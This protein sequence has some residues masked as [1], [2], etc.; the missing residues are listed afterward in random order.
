[1]DGGMLERLQCRRAAY[2]IGDTSPTVCTV[3]HQSEQRQE[4]WSCIRLSDLGQEHNCTGEEEARLASR[5]VGICTFLASSRSDENIFC[6]NSRERKGL[7]DTCSTTMKRS[8]PP[9]VASIG[10][11][12]C[13]GVIYLVL[14]RLPGYMGPP[15]GSPFTLFI[16]YEQYY[17]E[18]KYYWSIFS[19][20]RPPSPYKSEG[21]FYCGISSL[22]YNLSHFEP[23]CSS[24]WNNPYLSGAQVIQRRLLC[25]KTPKHPLFKT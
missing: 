7:L 17:S 8:A 16:G 14:A 20:Q 12:G 6:S 23:W 3:V 15:Q 5:A 25:T 4:W 1:M 18:H 13:S 9:A 19:L 22:S 10:A 24:G 2:Q 11:P 21:F